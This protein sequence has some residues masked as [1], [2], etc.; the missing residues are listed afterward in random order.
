MIMLGPG[1][2]LCEG[3][4]LMLLQGLVIYALFTIVRVVT[5]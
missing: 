2:S 1:D 5:Y 3:L 4:V